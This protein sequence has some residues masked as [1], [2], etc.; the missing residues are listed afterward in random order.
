MEEADG[1]CGGEPRGGGVGGGVEGG[2]EGVGDGSGGVNLGDVEVGSD[3]DG[4]SIY[5][6]AAYDEGFVGVGT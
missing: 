5:L 2:K 1:G 6:R 3:R 4:K